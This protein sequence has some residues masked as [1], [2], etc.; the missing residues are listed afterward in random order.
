MVLCDCHY[1]PRDTRPRRIFPRDYEVV[2]A[3]VF[4]GG[5]PVD[6]EYVTDYIP[7]HLGS[8]EISAP[9][10]NAT[11]D[12]EDQEVLT[13]VPFYTSIFEEAIQM[14][15]LKFSQLSLGMRLILKVYNGK[16]KCLCWCAC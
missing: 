16:K 6:D 1:T 10:F 2:S 8:N 9:I 11:E 7:P 12:N 14:F 4:H 13:D 3:Q 15:E 5:V